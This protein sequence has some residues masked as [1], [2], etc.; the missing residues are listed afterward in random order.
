[1]NAKERKA[2]DFYGKKSYLYVMC[3]TL[4]FAGTGAAF[5]IWSSF[6]QGPGIWGMWI[7]LCF[8]TIPAIHV[9]CKMVLQL[10]NRIEELEKRIE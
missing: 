7:P 9:L 8:I 1:M 4:F 6:S 5:D 10:Q 2:I 3:V